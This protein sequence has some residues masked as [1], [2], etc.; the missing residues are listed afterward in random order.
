MVEK[1]TEQIGFTPSALWV[2]CG[3]AIA[4][5]IIAV[6]IIDLIIKIRELRKPK[7]QDEKTVRELLDSDNKRIKALEDSTARQDKELRLILRSQMDII[8]HMI[9]GNGV[10]KMKKT[11][12]AIE[13]YLITG[14]IDERK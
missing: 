4:L 7:V 14:E 1:A 13:D 8:H 2:F 5:V 10:D 11:Q 3:V 9:D 6:L 12:A